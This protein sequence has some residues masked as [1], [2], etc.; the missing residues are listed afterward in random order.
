MYT[1]QYLF[2]YLCVYEEKKYLRST[3][4]SNL[5][6]ESFWLLFLYIF[7]RSRHI[8]H[9]WK[10]ERR[11]L[12]ENVPNRDNQNNCFQCNFSW[13]RIYD[14][15]KIFVFFLSLIRSISA[16]RLNCDGIS[17]SSII[18]IFLLLLFVI[19]SFECRKNE[20]YH[21]FLFLLIAVWFVSFPKWGLHK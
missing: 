8:S 17:R 2:R 1:S 4:K 14:V 3:V 6:G 10:Q 19:L 15:C 12:N 9:I 13:C 20:S 5:C 18:D 11:H 7:F 21:F 16:S